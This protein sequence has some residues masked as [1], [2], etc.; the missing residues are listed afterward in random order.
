MLG[1]KKQ[2]RAMIHPRGDPSAH[3]VQSQSRQNSS[4]R[5]RLEALARRAQLGGHG[6]LA[7]RGVRGPTG[8]A[9][10]AMWNLPSRPTQHPSQL[11]E[12]LLEGAAAHQGSATAGSESQACPQ[13]LPGPPHAGHAGGC[14]GTTRSQ[15]AFP[16]LCGH[17]RADRGHQAGPL[18]SPRPQTDL[19]A[20]GP[21][22]RSRGLA[23]WLCV[24]HAA[25][26]RRARESAGT[27]S[28]ALQHLS[29]P[30]SVP[31]W[32]W[33]VFLCSDGTQRAPW[34]APLPGCLS[35]N[36]VALGR[37]VLALAPEVESVLSPQSCRTL[38]GAPHARPPPWVHSCRAHA[39]CV[40]GRQWCAV[41]DRL[42]STGLPKSSTF[43]LPFSTR[44]LGV[45]LSCC[46][47][48]LKIV[49]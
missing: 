22:V 13:W 9:W 6:V 24:G 19:P 16:W 43:H 42:R 30:Q 21:R 20:A 27:S 11:P 2:G 3:H 12:G 8:A 10:K 47:T 15:F 48:G 5:P 45:V 23:S 35:C 41:D 44:S 39:G 26:A 33:Q 32:P 28:G 4:E 46:A 1:S 25:V 31:G 49:R 38:G 40:G 18:P 7:L 29:P 37:G 34:V 14:D 36:A 17:V